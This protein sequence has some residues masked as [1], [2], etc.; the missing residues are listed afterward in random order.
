MRSRNGR[1]SFAVLR[2]YHDVRLDGAKRQAR[3]TFTPM[4]A[5]TGQATIRSEPGLGTAM[6]ADDQVWA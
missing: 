2:R 4:T 6:K 3:C 1:W 5:E